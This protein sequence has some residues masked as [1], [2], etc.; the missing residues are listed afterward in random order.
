MR[1]L[2]MNLGCLEARPWA[3]HVRLGKPG[4]V[5]RPLDASEGA[6]APTD[7]GLDRFCG[8]QDRNSVRLPPRDGGVQGV[9]ARDSDRARWVVTGVATRELPSPRDDMGNKNAARFGA[10]TKKP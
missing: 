2:Y 9:L 3:L 4:T 1:S 7:C 5:S 8:R 6:D 10:A